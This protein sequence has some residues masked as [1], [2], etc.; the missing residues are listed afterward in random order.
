MFLLLLLRVRNALGKA[1][2]ARRL[3]AAELVVENA[4]AKQG[5]VAAAEN[6]AMVDFEIFIL[7]ALYVF[8][9]EEGRMYLVC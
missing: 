9:G 2:A 5:A 1:V 8:Y 4:L 3:D 7:V 6:A